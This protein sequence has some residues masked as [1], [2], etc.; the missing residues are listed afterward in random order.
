MHMFAFCKLYNKQFNADAGGALDIMKRHLQ[1]MLQ[2]G[3]SIV[4]VGALGTPGN[5]S[6]E[7]TQLMQ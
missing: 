6:L 1:I 2:R 4:V 3:S 7:L 5:I